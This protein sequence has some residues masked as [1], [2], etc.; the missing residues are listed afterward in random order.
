MFRMKSGLLQLFHEA[1]LNHVFAVGCRNVHK[2]MQ[3]AEPY[4]INMQNYKMLQ[5]SMI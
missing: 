2:I 1:V 4:Q 5:T 3:E